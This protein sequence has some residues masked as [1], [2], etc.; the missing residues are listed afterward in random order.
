VLNRRSAPDPHAW[1]RLNYTRMLEGF[2]ARDSWRKT[3]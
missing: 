2:R 1:E 3:P